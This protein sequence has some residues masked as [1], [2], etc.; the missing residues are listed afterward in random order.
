MT[1]PAGFEEQ[2]VV[3][4][5]T[6]PTNVAWA[7]D[8]RTFIVEKDGLLK[9]VAP[10]GSTASLVL[11]L[12]TRVNSAHDRGLLGLAVDSQFP[13]HP[14]LYLLYTYELNPMTPDSTSP[15]VS[16][17]LRV[18]INSASQVTEQTVLMGTYTSGVCGPC[19]HPGLPAV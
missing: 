16:Q 13:Q 4:G 5:L 7:P 10:G 19:E 2:Q 12:N 11:D 6:R 14:Y 3:G 8:G 1:Y 18:R 17:L 9:V 15:M